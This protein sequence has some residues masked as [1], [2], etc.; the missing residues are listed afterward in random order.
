[1]SYYQQTRP[2]LRLLLL[3]Q[4]QLQQRRPP[5]SPAPTPTPTPTATPTA[6]VTPTAH[7]RP[8]TY[9][10]HSNR[11]PRPLQTTKQNKPDFAPSRTSTR[12]TASLVHAQQRLHAGG[13]FCR[14][15]L[16]GCGL[17]VN[18]CGGFKSGWEL[19]ITHSLKRQHAPDGD[20][21]SSPGSCLPEGAFGWI[22]PKRWGWVPVARIPAIL[23]GN[24]KPDS[25]SF[26]RSSTRQL[27]HRLPGT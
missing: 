17:N 11:L 18:R 19:R 3:L 23:N 9:T 21:A 12:Q 25:V 10:V 13:A 15:L 22:V 5:R 20:L 6:T 4:L 24:G 26:T 7:S 2:R 1:M 14:T 16:A 8:I 27:K